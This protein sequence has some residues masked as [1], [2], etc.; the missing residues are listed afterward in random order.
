MVRS[1]GRPGE[2]GVGLWAGACRLGTFVVFYW[3]LGFESSVLFSEFLLVTVTF[4]VI[5]NPGNSELMEMD[6]G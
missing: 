4:S 6:N 2:Q 1:C 5:A 3:L